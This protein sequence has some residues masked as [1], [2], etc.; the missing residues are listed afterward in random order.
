VPLS[1]LYKDSHKLGYNTRD[2]PQDV[3][4]EACQSMVNMFPGHPSPQPRFGVSQWNTNAL[5]GAVKKSIP[6]VDEDAPKVILHIGNGLYWQA[7]GSGTINTIHASIVPANS[8]LSWVRAKD[9]LLI[10]NN[11]TGANHRAWFLAWD[12]EDEE[13]T[14]RNANIAWPEFLISAGMGLGS[15]VPANKARRYSFT[16]V[17]RNDAASVDGGGEPKLCRLQDGNFHPGLLESIVDLDFDTS[18]TTSGSAGAFEV[19]ID[20]DVGLTIDAQVT[21]LRIYATESA[22]TI[23]L[24][25]GLV[26]RWIVDIP[27][28]GDNFTSFPVAYTDPCTDGELAGA[29]DQLKT[30]GYEEIP[31]G[32]YML[33]HNGRIW[34]GGVGS[35]EEI[36]RHFYSETPQDVEYPQKWWTMFKTPLYF[37]DTCFEDSEKGQGI[38]VAGNDIIF[39][40]TVSLWYLQEGDVDFQPRRISK[41]KGTRFP[42]SITVR[43]KE[44][45]YL[46]NEGPAM[47]VG[48]E[49]DALEG[50]TAGEVWPKIHDNSTGYFHA[51]ADKSA[52]EGFYF[53]ETWWLTDGVKLVGL[54]LPSMSKAAGPLA[55]EFADSTIGFGKPCVLN[56]ETICL[57]TSGAAAGRIWNFLDKTVH[58]DNGTNFWLKS[59]SKA[60]YVSQRDRDRCGEAFN[61]KVFAHFE[62][63][64]PLFLEFISDFFR[65]NVEMDYSQIQVA[66]DI[67]IAPD[68]SVSFRNLIEQPT[69]EGLVFAFCEIAWRKEHRTPYSFT[70]KG[71]ILEYLPKDGH[72]SEFIS[73]SQGDGLVEALPDYLFYGRFNEDSD[74]LVD[75]SLYGRNHAYS[76][77]TG[78]SRGFDSTL[79]PDGGQDLLGGTASGYASPDWDG[80]DFI[81]D[82]GGFN[83]EDLT[84]EYVESFPSLATAQVIHE[85]GDGTNYWRLLV[86]EDGSLEYQILTSELAYVFT[87]APGTI[88]AGATQYNIQFVLSNGGM[89][90]QFY[91]APRTAAPATL[92]T[93]RSNL[94]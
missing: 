74:T 68:S 6:W 35:S 78:G 4:F 71:F 39:F 55:V 60:M 44:V 54:F 84:Y 73:R 52:V 91:A 34:V 31:P 11:L 16:L 18:F 46:S 81:G 7:A 77:G 38:A 86:N 82:D 70:H 9:M 32:T 59:K 88:V 12:T 22:D 94:E 42:N 5:S 3:P 61:I 79:V 64:A 41:T 67:R 62:D 51:V 24:T 13:F 80:M 92:L 90:G 56:Q 30:D 87:T 19:S 29:L 47:V 2:N 89:N 15:N 1:R 40:M 45:L 10:N 26:R 37:K 93:T 58:A 57:L 28:V 36:G 27:I 85:G 76:A 50:H 20:V 14:L 23:P 17:N 25:E 21:H 66:D 63:T 43:D 72:V 65:Y 69:P 75:Y 53:Q 83:S 48:R 33:F 49:A 8:K